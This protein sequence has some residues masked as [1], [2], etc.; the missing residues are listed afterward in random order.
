MKYSIFHVQGGIGKHVA[1]P[2]VAKAIKNNYPERQ[3][4]VV[5]AYPD[6]FI[7][8]DFVSRSYQLGNTS[9]FYQN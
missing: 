6:I 7:N 5:S 3:L 4:I 9:Y 2:A 8:L 1:A